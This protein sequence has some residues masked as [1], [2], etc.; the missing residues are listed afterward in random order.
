[1]T[2]DIA[3][4]HLSAPIDF[5]TYTYLQPACLPVQGLSTNGSR[6]M[7]IGWGVSSLDPN[8]PD[9]SILQEAPLP[10]ISQTYCKSR[11]TDYDPNLQLCAG[12]IQ[13]GIATCSGDS[14]GPLLCPFSNGV[15]VVE[16]IVSYHVG[17]CADPNYP[18]VFTRVYG[19]LSWIKSITG[20]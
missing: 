13:G 7:A 18:P 12:Y 6:C 3:L 15:W 17:E 10:T 5:K 14:G 9:T 2:N 1:M 20:L 19:Y 11:Y 8:A 16:G 4:L